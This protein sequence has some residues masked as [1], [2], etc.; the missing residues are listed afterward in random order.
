MAKKPAQPAALTEEDVDIASLVDNPR[1]PNRHPDEQLERLSAALATRGQNRPILA[2]RA[3]RMLI[4]G[5]GVRAA[6]LRLGWSTI[7]VAF[8]DVDQATAD[9]AMVADNRLGSLS[10]TED[11]R[12]AELLREIPETEWSSVGYS[13]E[14]GAAMLKEFAEAEVAV[15]RVDADQ[16]ADVFW[17]SVHGPLA[18]Q[19]AVLQFI[20]QAM[21]DFRGVSVEIGTTRVGGG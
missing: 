20:K 2:R 4:A 13:S 14:E 5:H 3:N 15:L 6:A 10:E 17:I 19:A 8:W 9:A 18:E 7:R 1:N 21:R 11:A 12:V 16:V